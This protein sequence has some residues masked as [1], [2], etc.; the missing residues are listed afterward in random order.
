MASINISLTDSLKDFVEERVK[1]SDFSTPSD[2]IRSLIRSD[3]LQ[4]EEALVQSLLLRGI[5]SGAPQKM[6]VRDWD[7]LWKNAGRTRKKQ[8]KRL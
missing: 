5:A 4:S 8:S 1:K 6:S 3:R 2:Y 7:A